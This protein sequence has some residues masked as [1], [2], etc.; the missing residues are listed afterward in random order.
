[1]NT[2]LSCSFYLPSSPRISGVKRPYCATP[3]QCVLTKHT[4]KPGL[5]I[6]EMPITETPIHH[7][8]LF[9]FSATYQFVIEHYIPYLCS[10]QV[11]STH[12]GKVHVF[13]KV[14]N[15]MDH[16]EIMFLYEINGKIEINWLYSSQKYYLTSQN[17]P[18][19]SYKQN[20]VSTWSTFYCEC[21]F[22][23]S[24]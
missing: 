7:H 9:T 16:S 17:E 10:R 14:M 18:I 3:A 22:F 1:M 2:V 6:R 12:Y 15:A 23:V 20:L 19:N 13:V 11:L 8:R 21:F 4:V 5:E 24:I